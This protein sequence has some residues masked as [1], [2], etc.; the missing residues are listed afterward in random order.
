LRSRKIPLE[1]KVHERLE[2]SVKRRPVLVTD[3]ELDEL[4]WP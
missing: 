4:L 2:V 3:N 1:P